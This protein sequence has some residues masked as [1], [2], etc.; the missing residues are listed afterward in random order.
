MTTTD[1]LLIQAVQELDAGTRA[2]LD[3][4]LRR[5]ISDERVAAAL[6]VELA[7]IPRRRAR[8][9]S[10]LA[11]KLAVPGPAELAM[12]LVALPDLPEEAWGVPD[13]SHPKAGPV[14]RAR[15][16]R[17]F[18]RVAVAASPL[19]AAAAVM[20]AL[21]VS[22]GGTKQVHV[23]VA[24]SLGA[25]QQKV[26]AT[27]KSPAKSTAKTP[28]PRKLTAPD[29]IASAEGP[30]PADLPRA[31]STR[32]RRQ[33]MHKRHAATHRAKHHKAVKKPVT[34]PSADKFASSVPRPDA[35][36]APAKPKVV[37]KRKR[38]VHRRKP[39][40]PTVPT[41]TP[42]PDVTAPLTNNQTTSTPLQQV[43]PQPPVIIKKAP[44]ASD[45]AAKKTYE[46]DGNGNGNGHRGGN[47][48]GHGGS[49]N[50]DSQP[51]DQG[52]GNYQKPPSQAPDQQSLLSIFKKH[53]ESGNYNS[54]RPQGSASP[55]GD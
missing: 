23:S 3:L 39:T 33:R 4:S 20:A 53:R 19:V 42:Q 21:I 55:Q 43:T 32:Q 17:A 46:N 48:C 6:G 27:P 25:A 35:Y 22:S 49:G 7:E 41:P 50:G 18:R 2:L 9:I 34:P 14:S 47:G 10:E 16:A 54:E 36:V 8:G 29:I 1:P 12:L 15:R 51:N 44:D 52:H 30:T 45:G 28:M 5:A 31:T 13:P 38:H 40:T 11:D 24:S 26:A 37:H